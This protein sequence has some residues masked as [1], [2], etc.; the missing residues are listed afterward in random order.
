VT[1]YGNTFGPKN[2]Y[3]CAKTKKTCSLKKETA[4]QGEDGLNTHS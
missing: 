4:P 3:Y 2:P 1:L